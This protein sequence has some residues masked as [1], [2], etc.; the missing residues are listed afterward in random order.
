M[1]REI[2]SELRIILIKPAHVFQDDQSAIHMDNNDFKFKNTKHMTVKV[3]FARELVQAKR[4]VLQ[5]LPV[6][7]HKPHKMQMSSEDILTKPLNTK[8][9]VKLVAKFVLK[10]LEEIVESVKRK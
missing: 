2:F 5:Y 8:Q 9:F 6:H 1:D 3:Y 4:V 7:F 10:P